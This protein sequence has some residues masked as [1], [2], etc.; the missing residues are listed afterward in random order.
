[1]PLLSCFLTPE[2]D[3]CCCPLLSSLPPAPVS[4][5]EGCQASG[6][7]CGILGPAR[8]PLRTLVQVVPLP[9]FCRGA[10]PEWLEG[11]AYLMSWVTPP[12]GCTLLLETPLFAF[13]YHA[14]LV[15]VVQEPAPETGLSACS[16]FPSLNA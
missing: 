15:C 5:R 7:T 11:G 16:F 9:L 12:W 4:L 14:N 1:M 10:A 2:S 13:C 3:P 8:L 6:R